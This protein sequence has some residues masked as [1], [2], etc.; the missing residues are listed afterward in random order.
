MFNEIT[1]MERLLNLDLLLCKYIF[2]LVVPAVESSNLFLHRFAVPELHL[3][4]QES[5][6]SLQVMEVQYQHLETEAVSHA[7]RRAMSFRAQRS[8]NKTTVC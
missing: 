8:G 7:D 1:A 4:E 5:A 6:V 2:L 3:A